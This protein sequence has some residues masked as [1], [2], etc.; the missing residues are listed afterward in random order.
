MGL[1]DLNL[2][3]AT[4]VNGLWSELLEQ[5]GQ[6][7]APSRPAVRRWTCKPCA[8]RLAACRSCWWKPAELA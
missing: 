4:P 6:A 8:V 2:A 5:L 3:E 7:E 1:I